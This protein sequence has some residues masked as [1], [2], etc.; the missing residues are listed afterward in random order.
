MFKIKE[1]L[2]GDKMKTLKS[3]ILCLVLLC[4]AA[5]L[6]AQNAPEWQWA[7]GAGGPV[8]EG[9]WWDSGLSIATDSQGNQ[10]VTGRF[11]G[12]A[13]FGS[14][15]LTASGYYAAFAAKLDPDGNWLWAAKVGGAIRSV[16]FGIAVDSAGNA[17]VT[18]RFS[19]TATFGSHTLTAYGSS[20]IFVAK[21]NTSG[22]WLWAAKAGGTAGDNG[23]SITVDG[24]G[25]AWVTGYYTGTAR[26]G[27]YTLT[28]NGYYGIFAAKLNSS[29]NW[30]WAAKADGNNEHNSGY[31][32]AVDGAGN[33]Y[34][35]GIFTGTLILGS[36][37]LAGSGEW[38]VFAA[39]L[40]PSGNWLWAVEAGGDDFDSVSGIAADDSGNACITGKFCGTA[41]FG[42]HTLT[43]SDDYNGD[44]FVAKLNSSGTWLWAVEAGEDDN[45]GGLAIT[46]DG[47]GNAYVTGYFSGLTTFGSHT[48][49][50]IGWADIF[51]AKLDP[52]GNWL[53]VV[54]AGGESSSNKGYGIAVDGTGN[55]YVTGNFQ[56]TAAFG[57]NTLTARGDWD[58]FVAKLGTPTGGGTPKAPQN[59]AITTNGADVLLNWDDV[60]E[61]INDNPLSVDH[62]LVYY[63]AT[64]PDGPFTVFG[65]DGSITQS[66]WTHSDAA[67]L[68]PGFYYVTAV[69]AD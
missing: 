17:Y 22:S 63:C 65:E 10:Y 25:N 12:T 42:S 59:L 47:E 7:V 66:Q 21:L 68:S 27:S 23:Y 51:A 35:T 9:E 31:G 18:G 3:L 2:L 55:A 26:F 50:S 36:H 64:C 28:A 61:D 19:G 58:I 37:T 46:L 40:S 57:N 15:T 14:H 33:A 43:S 67:S 52:S 1:Q 30:L 34:M 6:G 16:G 41:T 29:G 13:T 8:T 32:I 69:V 62:Y 54:Q 48:L 44:L 60:T 11:L 49:T 20:D 38:D 56:R 5:V 4:G 24:S 39:K 45:E 53:W